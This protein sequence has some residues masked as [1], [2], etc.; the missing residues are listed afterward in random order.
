MP[1]SFFGQVLCRPVLTLMGTGPEFMEMAVTYTRI[2]FVGLP[3]TAVLNCSLGIMRAQGDSTRPLFILS[4]SGI[5]NVALNAVFVILLGMDVD[6]VAYATLISVVV[7]TVVA[8]ACLVRDR[9][10]CHVSVKDLRIHPAT[11]RSVLAV[12]VPSGLQGMLFNISNMTIQSAINSLGAEF[13]SA[14][15]IEMNLYGFVFIAG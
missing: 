5:L 8:V 7:S 13:V 15:S 10:V 4:M 1:Y 9:G 12:G 2:R 3:F 11:L 14:A 6:G